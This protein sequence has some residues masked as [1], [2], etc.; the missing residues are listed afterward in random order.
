MILNWDSYTV[1][2]SYC[3]P[4]L[5]FLPLFILFSPFKSHLP[6]HLVSLSADF[7]FTEN[8]AAMREALPSLTPAHMSAPTGS[9]FLLSQ[10][11]E[12]TPLWGQLLHLC[13]GT[14]PFFLN[15]SCCSCNSSFLLCIF[16]PKSPRA[17]AAA[18]GT[19]LTERVVWTHKLHFPNL[20]FCDPTPLR[21]SS[22]HKTEIHLSGSPINLSLS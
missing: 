1:Q 6:I 12:T 15:Q 7:S 4:Y 14:H 9:I 11:M 20:L 10:W 21:C 13:P 18:A 19:D 16:N 8:I 17:A 22:M 2:P 5:I 3:V